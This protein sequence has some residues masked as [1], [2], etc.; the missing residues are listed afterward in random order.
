MNISVEPAA[1]PPASA[2]LN[3]IKEMLKSTGSLD[4]AKHEIELFDI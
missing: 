1:D 2:A 4:N 3:A